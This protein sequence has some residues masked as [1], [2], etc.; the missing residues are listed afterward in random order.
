[1]TH[2]RCE[3]LV[4]LIVR[5]CQNLHR[6]A[7]GEKLCFPSYLCARLF[8]DACVCHVCHVCVR[9]AHA[10]LVHKMRAQTVCVCV[11][12]CVCVTDLSVALG[13]GRQI[14]TPGLSQGVI[15][16]ST[17]LGNTQTVERTRYAYWIRW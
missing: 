8:V 2:A 12:V 14:C 15:R 5:L 7:T 4:D 1:M 16:Q 6:A 9:P 3:A 10:L 13:L 17:L 11:C